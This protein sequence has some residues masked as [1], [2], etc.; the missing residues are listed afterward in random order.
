MS[1]NSSGFWIASGILTGIVNFIVGVSI[2]QVL[3][4][5]GA[6]DSGIKMANSENKVSGLT[7][8]A[9]FL[10]ILAT[11]AGFTTF[12]MRYF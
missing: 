2:I 12:L 4:F 9:F 6:V 10:N 5:T 1:Q 8:A 11:F 7:E 3:S